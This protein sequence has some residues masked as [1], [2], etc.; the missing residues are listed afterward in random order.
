M[1]L[2]NDLADPVLD[3]VGLADFQSRANA[4]LLPFLLYPFVF[5]YFSFSILSVKGWYG[6]A[7]VFGLIGSR[8]L[9]PS[10]A[11]STSLLI[12]IIN[13]IKMPSRAA[14]FTLKLS[15]T[16]QCGSAGNHQTWL[17]QN[18]RQPHYLCGHSEYNVFKYIVPILSILCRCSQYCKGI[19]NKMSHVPW[20]LC[21]SGKSNLSVFR[22]IKLLTENVNY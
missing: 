12:I 17:L 15:T 6:G 3:G 11:L 14:T 1:S 2:W 8:S 18:I 7:G 16:N 13:K 19:S 10:L 20:R 22:L 4:F 5:Y 9:S 21:F